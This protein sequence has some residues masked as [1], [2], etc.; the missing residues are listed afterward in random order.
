M[1]PTWKTYRTIEG[2]WRVEICTEIIPRSGTTF[3]DENSAIELARH[4][5]NARAK[6]VF[7]QNS[8]AR[9]TSLKGRYD[10]VAGILT[11]VIPS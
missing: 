4:L 2:I 10:R 5:N 9:S 11:G 3:H 6:R 8:L 7:L 1:S